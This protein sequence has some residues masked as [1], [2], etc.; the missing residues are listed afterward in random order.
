MPP[1]SL[2]PQHLTSSPGVHP[3]SP[4]QASD[5]QS[6]LRCFSMFLS[7][8]FDTLF[9][10]KWP[11]RRVSSQM[12][13]INTVLQ[14]AARSFYVT[15]L[16]LK[17]AQCFPSLKRTPASSLNVMNCHTCLTVLLPQHDRSLIR[18][19][20]PWGSGALG[21]LYKSAVNSPSRK[22]GCRPQSSLHP[23]PSRRSDS[24]INRLLDH[25]SPSPTVQV[26]PPL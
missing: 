9:L 7:C 23:C 12:T 14:R 16:L 13:C 22:S 24:H 15:A 1:P 11:K 3:E 6:A 10:K 21:S 8:Y 4:T 20:V 5:L 17:R 19:A 2:F 25:L 26:R 18:S